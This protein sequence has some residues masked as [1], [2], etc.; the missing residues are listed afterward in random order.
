MTTEGD[1]A[2]QLAQLVWD[3]L[4]NPETADR[5]ALLA[6][7]SALLDNMRSGDCHL[8]PLARGM[9]AAAMDWAALDGEDNRE[10]LRFRAKSFY[11]ASVALEADGRL[12]T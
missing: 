5:G 8:A 4:T 11:M 12:N 3:A 1:S 2:R 10:A 6:A 7:A 9:A